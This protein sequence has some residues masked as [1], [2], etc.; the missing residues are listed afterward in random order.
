L[1]IAILDPAA[2]ASHAE[3]KRHLE[4]ARQLSEGATSMLLSELE[5]SRFP[6][7]QQWTCFRPLVRLLLWLLPEHIPT[8]QSQQDLQ[9]SSQRE[10][11]QGT[12]AAHTSSTQG[13]PTAAD[14]RNKS[15][16]HAAPSTDWRQQVT[17]EFVIIMTQVGSLPGAA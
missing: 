2:Q 9:G 7:D 11:C 3:A 15:N 1:W 12:S 5:S 8:V 17:L 10:A 14:K 13:Q 4:L 6:D 16:T